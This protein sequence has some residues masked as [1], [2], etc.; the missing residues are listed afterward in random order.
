MISIKVHTGLFCFVTHMMNIIIPPCR[1]CGLALINYYHES[2]LLALST[3]YQIS[4]SFYLICVQ[5]QLFCY[6]KPVNYPL[7]Y[8]S[9]RNK[10]IPF[11][12]RF[13]FHSRDTTNADFQ[14]AAVLDPTE[15]ILLSSNTSFLFLLWWV[16]DMVAHNCHRKTKNLMAKTT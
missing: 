5:L 15:Q 10:K 3:S 6:W 11:W 12:L 4:Y 8:L 7:F 9:V 14:W 2:W 1:T 13:I 16:A